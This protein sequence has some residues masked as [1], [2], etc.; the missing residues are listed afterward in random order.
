MSS[1]SPPLPSPIFD[2]L[3]QLN[4]PFQNKQFSTATFFASLPEAQPPNNT[5]LD[6]EYAWKFIYSYNGSPATFNVYR[7]EI[8]RLLQWA[9]LVRNCSILELKR[10]DLE[11][12]IRFCQQPPL[13][14]IGTKNVARFKTKNG[15]RVAHPEWRP[16]VINLP[17]TKSQ[18]HV[19]ADPKNFVF[20]QA[21][22]QAI[23]SVL[24]SFFNFLI[25]EDILASNPVLLIRQ[26]SKFLRKQQNHAPVRRIS[27]L[28]WQYVIETAEILAD[29]YPAQ[30]ERTLFIMNCLYGMYLRISELAADQRSTPIMGDFYKDMDNNWWFSVTGKGNKS[31][32]I[33]VCDEMLHALTRYRHARNLSPLPSLNES[34]VLIPKTLGRGP[35]SSTRQIRK[36]VQY[37]FDAA[38][39]RMRQDGL[40]DDAA[41]LKAATVHWLRHTGISEDIKFRPREHV[42]DDA[43]HASM[44][45]TDRYVESDL[46]ERHA[47][48]KKKSL[49]GV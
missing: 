8:E 20:S 48:G 44:Q 17:K 37:C 16:F 39:E 3:S 23:F 46:R 15:S 35:I 45:T 41:E 47:S 21:A 6:Y 30:H 33:A 2:N 19:T 49:Q 10:H 24:S 27:N 4:N 25:Q 34:T 43:G 14:W 11:D 12:Y 9:W 5:E 38:Y 36:I 28:Q 18:Q 32:K 1:N 22:V 31:R 40:A 13:S 42:R 29:E 26:K 7:R